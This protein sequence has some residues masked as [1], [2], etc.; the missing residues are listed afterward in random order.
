MV[1]RKLIYKLKGKKATMIANINTI[2]DIYEE[3]VTGVRTMQ[4]DDKIP[5]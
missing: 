4:G 2:Q 1:L 3:V 5:R